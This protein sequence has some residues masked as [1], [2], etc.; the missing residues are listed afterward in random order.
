MYKIPKTAEWLNIIATIGIHNSLI[1][2][3]FSLYRFDYTKIVDVT[4][5]DDFF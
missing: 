5:N 3:F 1:I 4:K 2:I